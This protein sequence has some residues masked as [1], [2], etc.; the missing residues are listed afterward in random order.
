MTAFYFSY[1]EK[2]L[3]LCLDQQLRTCSCDPAV[4]CNVNRC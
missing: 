2:K 1:R 4:L 3:R